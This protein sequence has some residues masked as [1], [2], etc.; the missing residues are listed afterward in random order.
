MAG[1]ATTTVVGNLT[2]DPELRYT[3]QG[4]PVLSFTVA[5]T[6]RVF[7]RARGQW[8]DGQTLFMRC[9]L[10][11]QQGANA[12]ESFKQG[13]RVIVHGKITQRS[14]ETRDGDKR[15]VVELLVEEMGASV[16]YATVAINKATRSTSETDEDVWSTPWGDPESAGVPAAIY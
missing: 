1:E 3:Q 14:F 4:V 5:S 13:A 9:A 8:T 6:P 15:T 11:G 10:F 12:S 2:A 16:K 7:D